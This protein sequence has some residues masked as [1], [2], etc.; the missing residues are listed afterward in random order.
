MYKKLFFSS[1]S[2]LETFILFCLK[3]QNDAIYNNLNNILNIYPKN[4]LKYSTIYNQFIF[5]NAYPSDIVILNKNNIN[6]LEL[7]KTALEKSM[8]STI[9]KE[10]VKYCTY[11][12]YSDRVEANQTQ[13]NFFLIVRKDK[14][15]INF[16]KYLEKYFQMSVAKISNRKKYNFTII[17]YYIENQGLL[18]YPI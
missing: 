9:E 2:D 14:K 17:E 13:I 4:N 12:S 18:F 15:N 3:N 16:K 10:I 1:E 7:K 5:G 8:I 6:I 11:S